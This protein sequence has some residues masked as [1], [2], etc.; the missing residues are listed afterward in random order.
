MQDSSLFPDKQ[1]AFLSQPKT[2]TCGDFGSS[3]DSEDAAKKYPTH[4]E[5]KRFGTITTLLSRGNECDIGETY[6][7][8][9]LDLEP[10]EQIKGRQSSRRIFKSH[11]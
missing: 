5:R 8:F 9:S 7:R 3:S 6:W 4:L 2:R 11:C 10:I 1:G